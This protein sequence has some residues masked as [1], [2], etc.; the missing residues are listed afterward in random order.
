[1]K[2]QDTIFSSKSTSPEEMFDNENYVDELKDAGF[3]II[4]T[5]IIK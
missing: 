5:N 3:K 4:I 1:M 2:D